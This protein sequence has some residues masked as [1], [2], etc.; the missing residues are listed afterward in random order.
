MY[1]IILKKNE[2]KS[3]KKMK[4]KEIETKEDFSLSLV[5]SR[6]S[7]HIVSA[8]QKHTEHDVP[9][10][11]YAKDVLYV[12]SRRRRRRRQQYQRMQHTCIHQLNI[13]ETF[14]RTLSPKSNLMRM[15]NEKILPFWMYSE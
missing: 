11:I 8:A 15:R 1:N 9:E 7:T 5:E 4:N 12:V 2:R 6:V 3:E 10:T 13:Y 14:N